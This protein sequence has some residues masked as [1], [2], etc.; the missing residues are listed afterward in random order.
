MARGHLLKRMK[1]WFEVCLFLMG[2]FTCAENLCMEN[3]TLISLV[4]LSI[5]PLCYPQWGENHV[6]LDKEEFSSSLD[7]ADLL[8]Y[9]SVFVDTLCAPLLLSIINLVEKR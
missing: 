1:I 2:K 6:F 3:Q 8:L 4:K 9:F 7:L 5:L